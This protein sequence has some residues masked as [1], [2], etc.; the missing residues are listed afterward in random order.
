VI[1]QNPHLR[2]SVD[3]FG[4]RLTSI[5]VN[6]RSGHA[7]HVLLGFDDPSV[8][9]MVPSFGAL[10]GRYANRIAGG[11]FS[12]DG[13]EFAL[14]RNDGAHTLHGGHGGFHS[15]IWDVLAQ[16][17]TELV[18]QHISPD[19]DQGFPGQVTARAT[20]R[21][22][23]CTLW[24]EWSATTTRPTVLN[25]STHPYF[26]LAGPDSP[27]IGAHELTVFADAWLPTDAA[28]I[29]TGD[30]RDVA[31]SAFDFRAPTHLSPRL[32]DMI[33]HGFVLR[34]PDGQLRL[35]ARLSHPPTGR[36]MEVHTTQPSL[37]VY[38][39]NKFNATLPGRGGPYQRWAGI[40]LEP[41]HFPNA[42]NEP[43]F[44]ST[45]LRPGET[46]R[47]TTAFTFRVSRCVES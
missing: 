25:L 30:I 26:N 12:L 36:A 43:A 42:P 7:T 33:D 14:A 32:A 11:R 39:A 9:R 29:P 45:L 3:P 37:Q 34:P 23:Q 5:E 41:Q 24:L 4:G 38:T 22:D 40:A 35:A 46:V 20:Y 44:P 1:L 27:D 8:Y 17:Q 6:D 16:S 13:Q 19:G 2:V 15:V 21:L 18:L 47:A 10:L 28:Q 31:G